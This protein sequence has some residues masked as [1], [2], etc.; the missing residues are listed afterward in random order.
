MF[1]APGEII[2]NIGDSACAAQKSLA[3][4]FSDPTGSTT[5]PTPEPGAAA[6]VG[7]VAPEGLPPIVEGE[8]EGGAQATE[9]QEST[10]ES[11]PAA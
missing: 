11:N 10:Q 8:R 2:Q 1:G 4:H 6:A 7:R 9:T 5:A 3:A